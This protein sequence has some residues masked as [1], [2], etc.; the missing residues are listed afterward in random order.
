MM[1][2]GGIPY[3]SITASRSNKELFMVLIN[4]MLS[5]TSWAMSLSPVLIKTFWLAL[6][7]ATAKVPM[8]S[9]ASTP[10]MT[11][12]GMPR[13]WIISC[14]GWICLR[15]SS[16]IGGRWDLYCSN[17]SSRKV[18]PFASKTTAIWLGCTC[19]IRLLSIFNTPYMAPVGSPAE[20]V[21]GGKA[22]KA[23]YK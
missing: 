13:A 14:N 4:I 10:S 21:S 17:I 6:E 9:S 15:R 22:W 8:T 5:S 20:L 2:S 3:F 23:R 1:S 11:K 7:A 18:L 19:E 16:G 12:R